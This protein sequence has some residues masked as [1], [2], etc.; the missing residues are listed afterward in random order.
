[1]DS[2]ASGLTNGSHWKHHLLLE[3]CGLL[4]T[5]LDRTQR[6][7]YSVSEQAG[8]GVQSDLHHGAARV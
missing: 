1:L 7:S 8:D 6:R 5:L 2:H 3:V 4:L